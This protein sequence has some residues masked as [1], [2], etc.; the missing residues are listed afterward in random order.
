[1]NLAYGEI[2]VLEEW[3]VVNKWWTDYPSRTDYA[4]VSFMGRK[5]TFKRVGIDP[6]W[7]IVEDV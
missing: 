5:V 4:V 3:S 2:V 6:V 1:M 7:R